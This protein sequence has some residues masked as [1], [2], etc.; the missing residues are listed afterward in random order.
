[1]NIDINEQQLCINKAFNLFGTAYILER[2][3]QSLNWKLKVLTFSGIA[4][5]LTIGATLMALGAKSAVVDIMIPII[6]IMATAQLLFSLWSVVANWTES[7]SNYLNSK[8]VNYHL[9]SSWEILATETLKDTF[10]KEKLDLLKSTNLRDAEDQKYHIAD[11]EKRLGYRKALINYTRVCPTCGKKPISMCV[12]G[13]SC[14]TCAN[15]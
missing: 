8:I 12:K 9:A 3:A 10:E 6:G 11:S 1:M 7:Y 15:F 2:R 13:L 5:P 4:L 14:D